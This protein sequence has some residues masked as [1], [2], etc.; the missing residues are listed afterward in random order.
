MRVLP[1]QKR[2]HCSLKCPN[3]KSTRKNDNLEVFPFIYLYFNLAKLGQWP[4]Y[5]TKAVNFKLFMCEL[6][7]ADT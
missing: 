3:F 2:S 5:Y 7:K 4:N 1:Y 6:S